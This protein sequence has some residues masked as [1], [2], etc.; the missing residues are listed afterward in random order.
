MSLVETHFKQ[1][2]A[3]MVVKKWEESFWPGVRMWNGNMGPPPP[4]L[5]PYESDYSEG[6]QNRPPVRKRARVV[7]EYNL[8]R[9]L[10]NKGS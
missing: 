8:K 7:A 9:Y 10:L 2:T 6:E 5:P 4:I 1:K 3:S